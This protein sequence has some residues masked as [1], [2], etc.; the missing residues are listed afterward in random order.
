[1]YE[2][3]RYARREL[4][5]TRFNPVT[6]GEQI[7]SVAPSQPFRVIETT[8]SIADRI[9]G[10]QLKRRQAQAM[11]RS[12]RGAKVT[13]VGER[14]VRLNVAPNGRE[15]ITIGEWLRD[16]LG[17][18]DRRRVDLLEPGTE[19][20]HLVYPRMQSMGAGDTDYESCRR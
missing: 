16:A 11:E 14:F 19:R 1:M 6:P 15:Q 17:K 8:S 4:L 12:Q 20:G 10:R 7:V 5:Q 2:P 3:W 13:G 9:P 18:P